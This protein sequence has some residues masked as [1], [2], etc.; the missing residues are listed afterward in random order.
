LHF[1]DVRSWAE[2]GIA[3]DRVDAFQLEVRLQERC[4][5]LA[6]R[7]FNRDKSS[8]DPPAHVTDLPM[9][10]LVEDGSLRIGNQGAD[11]K[12]VT[13]LCLFA[14]SLVSE[15][16]SPAPREPCVLPKGTSGFEFRSAD[17]VLRGFVDAPEFGSKHPVI[18][19]IHGS[20]ETDVTVEERS[21]IQLRDAF[22]KIGFAT[23]VWDK[24]GNGCSDGRYVS[25]LPLRQRTSEAIQAI[26]ALK[27]RPDVDSS[28]I[29]L[30][31]LS[32]G[33]WIAPMVAV[34]SQD[35]KFMIIVSGPGRDA[36]SQ[37]AYYASNEVRR[38]GGSRDEALQ[39]RS[40]LNRALAIGVSGGSVDELQKVFAPLAKYKVLQ[41]M[42]VLD[43]TS[44]GFI[45][46][47]R[48]NPEWTLSAD[49]LL[50]EVSQPTL[51]IFGEEDTNVDWQE[52][53]AVYRDAFARSGNA[54]RLTIKSFPRADHN[55]VR[56]DVA[57]PYKNTVLAEGYL[58]FM[59]TW[60]QSNNAV[61]SRSL[62]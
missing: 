56:T 30:W 20:P 7:G 4:P 22:R 5:L 49:L 3:A 38:T 60:L 17:N 54:H 1:Y 47:V 34:R 28:R 50:R 10:H 33:G 23:V 48:T 25:S 52:S 27:E 19:I 51:A 2:S 55:I 43:V 36:I 16:A 35:L 62:K 41:D 29:G 45:A 14:V 13:T 42:G 53:V 58:N 6:Q 31:A 59:M 40:T 46:A 44:R 15:L 21:Y 26:A 24:P 8:L 9:Q 18:L 57:E 12:T 39:V 37:G 11:V 61:D 32:Q